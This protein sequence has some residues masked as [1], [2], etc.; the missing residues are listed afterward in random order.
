M[1]LRD[2]VEDD[3]QTFFLHQ[4]DSEASKMVGFVPRPQEDFL[5]HWK[6]T[7]ATA[8]TKRKTVVV[9]GH[10]AGYV[11]S[12]DRSDKREVGY[13]LGRDFWNNGIATRALSEF[14]IDESERP[15]YARVAKRNPGSIRVL[16]KC[17]FIVDGSDRYSNRAGEEI[18]EFIF[19]LDKAA[20]AKH[21]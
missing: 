9:G 5:L 1:T 6:K 21:Q 13:W 4:L 8:R 14:L 11:G 3:L 16:D 15:L 12:F 7:S 17:G 20:H 2:T 19:R 10:V 18:E